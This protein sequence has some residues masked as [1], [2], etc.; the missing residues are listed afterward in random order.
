MRK[1]RHIVDERSNNKT[2]LVWAELQWEKY[3]AERG[4]M[5]RQ[6]TTM[7]YMFWWDS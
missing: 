5:G 7:N 4:Y 2:T 6:K 1:H 3:T